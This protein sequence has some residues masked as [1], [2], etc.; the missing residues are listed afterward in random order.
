MN[1]K[2]RLYQQPQI[3]VF[4]VAINHLMSASRD[5]DQGRNRVKD[6]EDS[7]SHTEEEGTYTF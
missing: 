4:S 7:N 5:E 6:W 3:S 2:V 1:K